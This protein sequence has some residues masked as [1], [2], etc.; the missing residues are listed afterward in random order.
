MGVGE[1][2]RAAAERDV[3]SGCREHQQGPVLR[4][5]A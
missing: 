2:H 1:L 3:S 5:P 4:E